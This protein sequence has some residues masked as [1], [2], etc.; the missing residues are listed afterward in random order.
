MNGPPLTRHQCSL[1][2]LTGYERVQ[3][4]PVQPFSY[5][6]PNSYCNLFCGLIPL[7]DVS[8]LT[9]ENTTYSTETQ[10]TELRLHTHIA[11]R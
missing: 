5:V 6:L 1:K 10:Y 9:P 3:P 2:R 8:H 4:T 7:K 11:I